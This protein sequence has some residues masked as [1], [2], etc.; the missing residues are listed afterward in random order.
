MRPLIT[1]FVI[2]WVNY[3]FVT[4]CVAFESKTFQELAK[5]QEVTIDIHSY[6]EQLTKETLTLHDKIAIV[7][8]GLIDN[9]IDEIQSG[10][11]INLITSF[12]KLNVSL[13]KLQLYLERDKKQKF[14]SPRDQAEFGIFS[15]AV[16]I[17]SIKKTVETALHIMDSLTTFAI[18][19]IKDWQREKKAT[20]NDR[21]ARLE[22]YK[23]K[24]IY[25]N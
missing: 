21:I 22:T 8:K 3:S 2:V 25:N 13:Q 20:K 16:A 23:W 9:I 14:E 10:E 19:E 6:K 4:N 11:N 15:E 24:L 5:I 12:Q 7:V 1:L 18:E 17:M